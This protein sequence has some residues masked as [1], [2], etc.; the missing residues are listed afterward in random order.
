M[1]EDTIVAVST[2]PG[3]GGIGVIR[4]SGNR[5]LE[6]A[7]VLIRLPQLPLKARHATLGEFVDAASKQVLDRVMVTFFRA[8]HSY[9]AEDVVEISCHGAPVVLHCL[10]ECC[11]AKGARL[12][13]PGEFT[14]RAFLN[15]RIDLTQAEA[16]RDLIDS[17]TLFQARMAAQQMEGAVSA[18]LRPVKQTL[19]DLIARMEAGIDFAEDEVP[20]AAND[21]IA[22]QIAG[23]R[24]A[25][26]K[27]EQGYE[28]GRFVREGISL[29]IVG[30]P[31]VGKSSLFNC[32]LNEERAIVTDSPGTTRDLVSETASIGGIPVRLV[33]TAGIRETVDQVERIGVEKSLQAIADSDLRLLVLDAAEGW[34]VEDEKL[35]RKIRPLGRLVVASNKSDLPSRLDERQLKSKIAEADALPVGAHDR[36]TDSGSPR[37]GAFAPAEEPRN[38]LLLPAGLAVVKTSARTRAGIHTLQQALLSLLTPNQSSEVESEVITNLRHQQSIKEAIRFLEKAGQAAAC[39]VPHEMLLLDLYDSLHSLDAVTGATTT[40]DLL[41]V[42]FSTFCVGK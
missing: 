25:L 34:L 12:A 24:D 8:P 33:D 22:A 4:L 3:R 5:A 27:M 35:F 17:R 19:I 6:I 42:I 31:N 14:Q 26:E 32:L 21:G 30:R 18:R 1:A 36:L 28:F 41:G 37:P 7:S 13:E 40:E 38:G 29:A 9:T 11:I 10:V 2:P 16:I 15:G 23:I 39:A 20:V